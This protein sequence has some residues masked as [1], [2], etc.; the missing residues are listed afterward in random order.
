MG[1]K[2]EADKLIY[3]EKSAGLA[4]AKAMLQYSAKMR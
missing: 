1:V 3:S 4:G 2:L